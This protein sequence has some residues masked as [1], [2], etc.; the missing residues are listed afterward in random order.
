M[1]ALFKTRL[2]L[3]WLLALSAL[4]AV[5]G[6]AAHHG[7]RRATDEE[8]EPTGTIVAARLGNPRGELTLDAGG[9]RWIA[10]IGQPWRNRNAGLTDDLPEIGREVTIHGHRWAMPTK[11]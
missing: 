4:A 10:E 7:W 9:D 1:S 6:A 3:G 5:Q 11:S 8:F 2:R